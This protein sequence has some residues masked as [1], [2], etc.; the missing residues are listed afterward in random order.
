MGENDDDDDTY[1]GDDGD[2]DDE[3][4]GFLYAATLM[5]A[6]PV[7]QSWRPSGSAARL[8]KLWPRKITFVYVDEYRTEGP[9]EA[10]EH[11]KVQVHQ[12]TVREHCSAT[13]DQI[14]IP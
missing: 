14:H 1:D 5:Y 8:M 3:D 9:L 2:D 7:A 11:R 13:N 10:E 4:D 6:E 12:T